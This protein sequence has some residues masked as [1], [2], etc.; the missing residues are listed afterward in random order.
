MCRRFHQTSVDRA[1][2]IS[3]PHRHGIHFYTNENEDLK[4]A[5]VE[6]FNRTLKDKMFR[7]FTHQN[8]R[9]YVDVLDDMLYSHNNSYHR[10][11]EM[12]SSEVN[13]DNEDV[14]RA[15]LY[16]SKP[17]TFKWKYDAGDRVRITMQRQPLR[18]G[19]LGQW[20]LEIFEIATLLPTTPVTY[21]LRDLAG[22]TIKGR[23][24]EPEIKKVLMSDDERF[25]IDRIIKTRK[26]DG[27]IQYLVA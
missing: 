26:R 20:S 1:G 10:S 4:A 22:E 12:A 25:D 8:T 11:I 15:R 13:E 6:R 19:Y 14:V 5:I 2:S 7:Y 23:F 24:Y 21:E 9:R 18:K 27:K 3:M 17:K 16:P